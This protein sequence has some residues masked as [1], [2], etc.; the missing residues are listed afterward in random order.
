MLYEIKPND[1]GTFTGVA[2]LLILAALAACYIPARQAAKSD[3][4]TA[5]R[6]E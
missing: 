5:L 2:I 3:P 1:P 6:N 4:L